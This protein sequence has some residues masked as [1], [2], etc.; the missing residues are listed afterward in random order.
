MPNKLTKADRAW[1]D[2]ERARADAEAHL[3]KVV[4]KALYTGRQIFWRHGQQTRTGFVHSVFCY[5]GRVIVF[6]R[7]R[8]DDK[9]KHVSG[10]AVRR[11][12]FPD[13]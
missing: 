4:A 7:S 3:K 11:E 12:M 9:L 2:A 5:G 13:A 10:W 8:G 6:Y 1:L